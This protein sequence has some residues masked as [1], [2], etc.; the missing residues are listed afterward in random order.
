MPFSLARVANRRSFGQPITILR[1]TGAFG[2]GGWKETTVQI[3][4]FGIIAPA[5][6]EAIAQLPEADRVTGSLQLII[7]QPVFETQIERQ[8]TSDRVQWNGNVYRVA[9][10][11]PWKDFGFYSAIL[12]RVTGA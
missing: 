2:L 3:S 4:A 8:G 9:G 10:V 11:A 12:V 5:A 1:S 7:Q 6:D